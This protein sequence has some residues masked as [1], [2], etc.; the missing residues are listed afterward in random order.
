MVVYD[1]KLKKYEMVSNS[2]RW[3]EI[4]IWYDVMLCTCTIQNN[5]SVT[6]IV[7]RYC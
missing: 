3:L 5:G 2:N 6:E 4:K 7:S 1:I